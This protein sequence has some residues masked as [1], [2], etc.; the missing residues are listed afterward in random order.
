MKQFLKNVNSIFT[1]ESWDNTTGNTYY[2]D[3]LSNYTF[4]VSK[5][6]HCI[7]ISKDPQECIKKI[8]SICNISR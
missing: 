3:L 6:E 8:K 2:F 1:I 4:A 5:D 7:M